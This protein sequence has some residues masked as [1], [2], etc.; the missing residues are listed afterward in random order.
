MMKET[1]RNKIN[2]MS[3]DDVLEALG[4]ARRRSFVAA[5]VPAV[6][7]FAAGVLVGTG[8]ALLTSPR[9]GRETR[10][11]LR[12]RATELKQRLSSKAGEVS[13][14][15]RGAAQGAEAGAES[16]RRERREEPFT[17]AH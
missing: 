10:R 1:V 4:L 2:E 16:S 5:A 3:A 12:E 9:A 7:F 14:E 17:G 8:I 15:V 13:E 11:E 6:G